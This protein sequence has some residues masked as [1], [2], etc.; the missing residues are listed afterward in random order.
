VKR[1]NI[2]GE[3]EGIRWRGNRNGGSGNTIRNK[4]N[5]KSKGEG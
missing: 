4:R 1:K 5:T 2:R 3:G